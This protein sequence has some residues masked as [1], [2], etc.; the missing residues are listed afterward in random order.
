MEV[1]LFGVGGKGNTVAPSCGTA[2]P[3]PRT[4]QSPENQEFTAKDAKGATKRRIFRTL[5]SLYQP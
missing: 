2:C 1:R 3:R 4:L 5:I